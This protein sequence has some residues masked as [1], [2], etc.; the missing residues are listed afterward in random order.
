MTPFSPPAI[1]DPLSRLLREKEG[2][3]K[4]QS[5]G[6]LID[7]VRDEIGRELVVQRGKERGGK[8][9]VGSRPEEPV[10]P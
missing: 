4:F 9:P 1:S 2:S 6:E 10:W 8:F 5:V 7:T 3:T